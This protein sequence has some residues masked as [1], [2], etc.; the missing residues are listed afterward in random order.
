VCPSNAN[1]V[2]GIK[3]TVGLV[4][5][6]GIIPI[7]HTQDT[8]GPMGRSL[9]DAALVLGALTG[10]D[11]ADPATRG[12]EGNAHTG[13]TPFLDL[14]GLQGAR[15]GVATQYAEGHEAVEAV[16]QDAL[17]VMESA[18]ATV[19]GIPTLDAWRQM[20]RYSSTLMRYEFKAGLNAYLTGL[21]PDA[22]VKSLAEIIAFNRT[23]ADDE[24]PFFGQEIMLESEERGP[25]TDLRYQEAL[26]NAM[27]LSRD[28]GI[29]RV[30]EEHALDAIV[31]PTGSPAWTTDLING[32]RYSM[33]S[34]SP[35]AIA[36]YPN[37]S[38]PMGSFL[39]LPMNISFWGE[40]WSEPAL[41]RIAYAFEERTRHR[42]TP[43]FIPA[44]DLDGP[45]G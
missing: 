40:A 31:A 38:V 42:I 23:R 14:N 45:P 2:A 5:R 36:G 39:G 13:Y 18:G 15:I 30:M 17:K 27:R 35:A 34:S 21:G 26:A 44:L 10:V 8:A 12:S 32:D 1:G 9:R 29:D 25:L 43:T 24:M 16:F 6:S 28:E 41:L 33:G 3:P 7:S 22:P 37:I 19:V 11:P 20:G 4:S